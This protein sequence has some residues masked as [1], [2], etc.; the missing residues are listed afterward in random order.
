MQTLTSINI[1]NNEIRPEGP[2]KWTRLPDKND[3]LK[4]SDQQDL[5]TETTI[6]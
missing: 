4:V 6:F 5:I 3:N 1:S 2:I